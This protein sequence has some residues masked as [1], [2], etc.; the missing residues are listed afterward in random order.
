MRTGPPS[1]PGSFHRTI[2]SDKDAVDRACLELRGFLAESEAARA[3]FAIELVARELLV[4]AVLH[5]NRL[6][7]EKQALVDLRI[8]SRWVTLRVG[9]KGEGFD[10]RKQRSRRAP[11]SDATHGRGLI[12][13]GEYG[14][15]ITFNRAGNSVTV[16]FQKPAAR[17]RS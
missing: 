1:S 12:I 16:W 6:Q 15:R 13:A 17:E 9:D 4:N 8:G 2:P 11:S 7:R 14:A 5:G 10:W 3:G